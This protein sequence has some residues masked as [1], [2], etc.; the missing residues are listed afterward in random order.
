MGVNLQT[1]KAINGRE[2]INSDGAFSDHSAADNQEEDDF[3][4]SSFNMQGLCFTSVRSPV[5]EL[6][7]PH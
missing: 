6:S 7:S 5:I 3:S 2:Y 1:C 4:F